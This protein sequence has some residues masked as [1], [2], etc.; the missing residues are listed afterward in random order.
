MKGFVTKKYLSVVRIIVA[1][2]ELKYLKV[3]RV[4][5]ILFSSWLVLSNCFGS[6]SLIDVL[7]IWDLKI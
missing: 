4:V 2:K 3:S 7:Y 5:K 1:E 6:V